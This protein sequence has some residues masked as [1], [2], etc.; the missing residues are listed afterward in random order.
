M[1]WC[2]RGDLNTDS[3][4][5]SPDRGNHAI[6]VT[7]TGPA[8]TVIQRRVRYLTYC[9]AYYGWT[10]GMPAASSAGLCGRVRAALRVAR[11]DAHAQ[12]TDGTD[13]HGSHPVSCGIG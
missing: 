12:V 4:A 9:L 10:A 6:R 2:P 11:S 3:G 13:R 8:S 5:I 7:C 1:G